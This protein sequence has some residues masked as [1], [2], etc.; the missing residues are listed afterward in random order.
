MLEAG[1]FAPSIT[2]PAHPGTLLAALL[3]WLDARS[4]GARFILRFEDLDPQRCTP[5]LADDMLAALAWLGIDWDVLEYQQQ[6]IDR[7][8]AAM[9]V[10]A[11]QGRLYA[12]SCSRSLLKKSGKRAADGSWFYPGTCRQHLLAAQDWRDCQQQIRLRLDDEQLAI[13]DETGLDLSQNPCTAMGDPI[14]RRRDGA[15]AYQLVVVVDDAAQQI[16]RVVRGSDLA[17]ST[18]T[19]VAIQSYLGLA[20]PQYRHHP[21]LLERSDKKLAKLHGSIGWREIAASYTASQF[22]A[23]LVR[24][25]GFAPAAGG[26]ATASARDVLAAFDWDALLP[27]DR[28]LLW[29]EQRLHWPPS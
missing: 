27:S 1:R 20:R 28:L 5:A 3:A 25:L 29:Q 6:H 7:Y 11:Q 8:E 22:L 17:K 12:C 13:H 10:L 19:Q 24:E 23:E 2:G 21:L 26:L 16:S 9:D 18:A 15:F 4:R 14:V